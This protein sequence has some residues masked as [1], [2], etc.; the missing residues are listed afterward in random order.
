MK[1]L[2]FIII[3]TMLM[4]ISFVKAQV[5]EIDNGTLTL[6]VDLLRGG[7]I[8]Y[9]ST[10]GSNRNLVNIADEG[11]YIQQSYYAGNSINRQSE[12]QCASWSPWTWNPIQAGSCGGNR[13]EVLSQNING[14]TIY[15]KCIPMLWDMDNE[16]AE[17]IMEQWTTI[18][19]N[20][21]KVTN[22]ITCER[23]I[24]D[25][26]GGPVARDQEL[27]AVYPI[28]DFGN[29]YTYFGNAPFTGAPLTNLP[30]I[31]LSSGFWGV[32]RG[33][34]GDD[35]GGNYVTE[36]WMAFVDNSQFGMGVY[37]PSSNE[38]IAGMAGDPNN[39][40]EATDGATSY[41]APLRVEAF[42]R[43]TVYEFDYYLVIGDLTQIRDKVYEIHS[44]PNFG[45]QSN[46]EFTNN[47]EGWT[48]NPHSLTVSHNPNG[49]LN[50]NI[51]NVDPYVSVQLNNWE[52]VDETT[53]HM[54]IK[55]ETSDDVGTMYFFLTSGGFEYVSFPLTPNSSVFQ[56]VY[57]D[58]TQMTSWNEG[59]IY[60]EFRIDPINGDDGE[61]G[62]VL[63]DFIRI[64]NSIPPVAN[65]TANNT[66][67]SIDDTINFTDQ[68]TNSPNNWAWD[69]NNDGT[70]DANIQ[71]PS[72]TYSTAGIYTV[73]LVATNDGGYDEEVKTN[74]ITVLD[75]C[76]ETLTA[77]VIGGNNQ[78]ICDGDDPAEFTSIQDATGNTDLEYIWQYSDDQS[79]WY[80]FDSI[81]TTPTLDLPA[82]TYNIS[83]QTILY[84]HRT[85]TDCTEDTLYSNII[86]M[87]IKPLPQIVFNN[88]PE[89]TLCNTESAIVLDITPT[90]G[91]L[92]GNGIT[93]SEF[94]PYN[95]IIGENVFT[96][97]VTVNGC[98]SQLNDT[99]I[100]DNCTDI[101]MLSENELY[102]YPNPA[103]AY[104]M[105]ESKNL[106]VKG[107]QILD[108]TGKVVTN[109]ISSKT[110]QSQ[111]IDITN[112]QDGV[113]FIK[114]G[115]QVKKFIKI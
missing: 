14:N 36:N 35:G 111:Y 70:I 97:T 44:N 65:F 83:N 25:A 75:L 96:Y 91:S 69:F 32:Y 33:Q 58:L 20:V 90:G 80:N 62:N 52:V 21:V 15:T 108:I 29:L 49:Y 77:G 66:T 34:A 39:G 81:V 72:Y 3:L 37:T 28:A 46:W 78:I 112:L 82:L 13:A 10:S 12:G 109:V 4:S 1:T 114:I 26:W 94:I 68:S 89:N 40:A 87:T 104:L 106:K 103:N 110:K 42:D 101:N 59:T 43:N 73:K 95:A 9:I 45:L 51:N 102:I 19:G 16:P 55:N 100:V 92:S 60:S 64:S 107:L 54:R 11:R 38:F 41:I 56:D 85:V 2:H 98:T 88:T 22:K 115:T 17:A 113:Y 31:N 86:N 74:Y 30:T 57:I 47:T 7:A 24:S 5:L 50:L 8:S 53:L 79:T 76:P 48:H 27:P 67:I 6:K 93:G 84:V 23:S 105:V 99:I 71:N 18:I 63:I 61:T